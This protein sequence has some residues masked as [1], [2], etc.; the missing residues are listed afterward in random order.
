MPESPWPRATDRIIGALCLT[1][2]TPW[3]ACIAIA[4]AWDWWRHTPR[5]EE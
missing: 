4:A 1:A 3:L 5:G 2:A